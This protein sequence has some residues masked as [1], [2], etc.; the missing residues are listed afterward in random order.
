MVLR[1]GK[2][3]WEGNL[4]EGKGTME[5]KSGVF[6]GAYSFKSRFKDGSGTNPEEL[7]GAAHAGCF[8]MALANIL[9]E[10]GHTPKKVS[11]SAD[12]QLDEVEG[13]PTITKIT[14][15]TEAKV[16]DIDAGEFNKYA[17]NAKDGCPVSKA[18]QGIDIALNAKLVN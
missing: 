7:I 18:L 13:E 15:N 10:A 9:A 8:S 12:V 14:L 5:L 1:K 4:K 6:K 3:I 16:P 17:E 11:T 2:A